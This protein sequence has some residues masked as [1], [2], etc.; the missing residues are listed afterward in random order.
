VAGFELRVPP[1]AA[2]SLERL[3]GPVA[4]AV[5]RFIT[6]DLLE[7]PKRVGKPLVRKLAGYWSARRGAY[8]VIY[9]IDEGRSLVLVVRIEH[10]ADIVGILVDPPPRWR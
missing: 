8:R 2:R 4:A 3:P 9:A 10:R 5:V 7:S 6:G 1:S